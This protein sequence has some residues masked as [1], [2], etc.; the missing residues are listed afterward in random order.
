MTPDSVDE[1]LKDVIQNLFEIQSSVHGYLGPETQQVLVH[2][3]RQLSKSL[4]DLSV[5]S[6]TLPTKIPPEIIDYVDQG[7]NPDIYTREMVESV[8]R[9]NMYLKGK[10][11]AFAGFR[12]MLADEIV[13]AMPEEEGRVRE[14]VAGRGRGEAVNVNGS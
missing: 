5:A 9:N 12:D 6:S 3:I 7:R 11:E 1:P 13:K 4:S 14:I 8:Q 2:K 10:S